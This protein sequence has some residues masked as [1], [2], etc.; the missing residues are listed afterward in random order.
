MREFIITKQSY[1]DIFVAFIISLHVTTIKL[2]NTDIR[3]S[4]RQHRNIRCIWAP[5]LLTQPITVDRMG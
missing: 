1:V 2:P 3:Q 4:T 5:D